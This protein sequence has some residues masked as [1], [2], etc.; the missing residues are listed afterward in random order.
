MTDGENLFFTMD[1]G[2]HGNELWMSDGTAEGTQLAAD[3]NPGPNPSTPTELT[4]SNGHLYFSATDRLHGA[5]VWAIDLKAAT[6]VVDAD[7]N[8]DGAT[9]FAD[10]QVLREHF[11]KAID[12]VF[13]QGDLDNDGDIDFADFLLLSNAHA[14]KID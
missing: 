12:V 3:I 8:G 10:F 11:G 5:E 1:G 6:T 4:I 2:E 7:I 13:S 14:P 9:D